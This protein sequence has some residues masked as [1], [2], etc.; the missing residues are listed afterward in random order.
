MF[1]IMFGVNKSRHLLVYR[2]S[3]HLLGHM[4][5]SYSAVALVKGDELAAPL[6]SCSVPHYS[7]SGQKGAVRAACGG[8]REGGGAVVSQPDQWESRCSGADS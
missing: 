5:V 2:G 4:P 1:S 8:G 7:P 3:R 6:P